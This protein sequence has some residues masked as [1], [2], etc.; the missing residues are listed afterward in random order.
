MRKMGKEMDA[1]LNFHLSPPLFLFL[2]SFFRYFAGC[3]QFVLVAKRG[4]RYS[5]KSGLIPGTYRYT[6][7][8][9][10]GRESLNAF[11][12]VVVGDWRLERL[13]IGIGDWRQGNCDMGAARGGWGRGGDVMMGRLVVK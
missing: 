6:S 11:L 7:D 5:W 4:T 12:T 13:G 9:D 3:R 2:T 10:A 1:H 8:Y